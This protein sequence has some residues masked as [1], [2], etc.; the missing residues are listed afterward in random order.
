MTCL[1]CLLKAQCCQ[2]KN[3][4]RGTELKAQFFI[5]ENM[6]YIVGKLLQIEVHFKVSLPVMPFLFC[7]VSKVL[8]TVKVSQI[9][10]RLQGCQVLCP[11][12]VLSNLSTFTLAGCFHQEKQRTE[13][14]TSFSHSCVFT[15]NVHN[16]CFCQLKQQ[17][18]I[19]LRDVTGC[20]LSSGSHVRRTLCLVFFYTSAGVS[21]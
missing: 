16:S 20:F 3:S 9:S 11:L 19:I 5:T 4:G 10:S 2:L 13:L 7:F 18:M 6:T 12:C 14:E 8:E 15:R 21:L 17:E 1:H